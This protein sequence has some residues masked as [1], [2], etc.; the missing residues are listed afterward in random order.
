MRI[1]YG[2]QTSN[3]GVN[4]FPAGNLLENTAAISVV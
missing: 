4:R 3:D 1:H 2:Q